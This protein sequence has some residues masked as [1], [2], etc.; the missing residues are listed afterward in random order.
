MENC[1]LLPR[2]TFLQQWEVD[3]WVLLTAPSKVPT[4]ISTRFLQFVDPCGKTYPLNKEIYYDQHS[5]VLST[6][7]DDYWIQVDKDG[8]AYVYA[9]CKVCEYNVFRVNVHQ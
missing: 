8:K 5:I 7:N 6:K 9:G 1:P 4:K 2:Q 3:G